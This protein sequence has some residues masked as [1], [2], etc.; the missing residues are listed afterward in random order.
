MYYVYVHTVPNGKIYIGQARNLLE[1][2]NNGEGYK[3][4]EAFY[5]DIC[6]YGWNKIRH[7]V[8]AEYN[9][10][11]TAVRL[12]TLLIA[13]LKAENPDYGYNQTS[14][15]SEAMDKYTK[16]VVVQSVS[17]ETVQYDNGFFESWNLPISACQNLIDQWIFSERDRLI[18]KRR[19]IDG[20]SY[21]DISKETGLCIRQVKR[22][23][24]GCCEKLNQHL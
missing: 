23:V 1:R 8:I 9:E 3:Q 19:L 7:E 20:L 10:R 17:L 13:L 2:W 14:F 22:I 11:E 5:E 6:I 15:Y 21:E 4:N 18:A 12:E 24:S 16:R